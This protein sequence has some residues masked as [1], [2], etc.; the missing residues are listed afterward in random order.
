MGKDKQ[1][2]IFSFLYNR[3]CSSQNGHVRALQLNLALVFESLH[4]SHTTNAKLLL[5]QL[6]QMDL[7]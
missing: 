5:I 7:Y 6:I 2:L 1:R 4:V 3:N